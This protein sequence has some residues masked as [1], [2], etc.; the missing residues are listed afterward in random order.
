MISCQNDTT[1][2]AFCLFRARCPW[3][4]TIILHLWFSLAC[5]AQI[6]EKVHPSQDALIRYGIA[7]IAN[8]ANLVTLTPQR[9]LFLTT[10][11]S[12]MDP[13]MVP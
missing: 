13:I 1:S 7:S 5:H 8:V 9:A 4:L 2:R 10:I 12:A 11:K 6:A 3:I